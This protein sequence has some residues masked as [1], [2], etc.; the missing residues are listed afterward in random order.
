MRDCEPEAVL[1]NSIHQKGPFLSS[2]C[3]LPLWELDMNP[4]VPLVQ[5]CALRDSRGD[6]AA[7]WSSSSSFPPGYKVPNAKGCASNFR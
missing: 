7:E 5:G 2:A 4:V 1:R 3:F 6:I